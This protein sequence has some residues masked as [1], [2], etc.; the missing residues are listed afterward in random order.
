[1]GIAAQEY[2]ASRALIVTDYFPFH[3]IR[4]RAV[5]DVCSTPD[6]DTF[7]FMYQFRWHN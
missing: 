6:R 4:A 1:M 7:Q 5:E 3:L 2:L